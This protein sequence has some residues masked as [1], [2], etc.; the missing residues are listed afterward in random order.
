MYSCARVSYATPFISLAERLSFSSVYPFQ[1]LIICVIKGSSTSASESQKIRGTKRKITA[2]DNEE[3]TKRGIKFSLHLYCRWI[4]RF[5]SEVLVSK[6]E[7][8]FIVEIYY[9]STN[10]TL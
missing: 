4:C 8:V 6:F 7:V 10:L 1:K 3:G 2:D 9:Y 5:N